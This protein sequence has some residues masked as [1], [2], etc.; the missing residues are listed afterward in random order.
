[1]ATAPSAKTDKADIGSADIEAQLGQVRDDIAMLAKSIAA[2][3][4][5]K[6]TALKADAQRRL[7]NLG[8]ASE[9][10]L[11]SLN[12]QIGAIEKEISGQVRDRPLTTL[13]IAAGVGF[14]L[15]MVMRR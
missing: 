2:L 7:D 14:L 3:G 10:V 11:H 8:T 5:N 6:K 1:M 4:A 13:G 12:R 15:A 9:E